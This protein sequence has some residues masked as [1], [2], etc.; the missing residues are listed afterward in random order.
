MTLVLQRREDL[1]TSTG[2]HKGHLL[3]GSVCGNLEGRAGALWKQLLPF[4]P[5]ALR[6][7]QCGG[8]TQG[9]GRLLKFTK[10]VECSTQEAW[11]RGQGGAMP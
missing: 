10:H 11:W 7:L 2:S 6:I 3:L 4:H 1:G 8:K 5:I 9:A